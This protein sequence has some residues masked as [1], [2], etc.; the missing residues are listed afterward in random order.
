VLG[1]GLFGGL[2]LFTGYGFCGAPVTAG[3]AVL[4][5]L[6]ARNGERRT[7][8]LILAILGIAAVVFAWG[9]HWDR[10]TQVFGPSMPA[11][12]DYPRFC[13]LMFTSLLG[14][15][16]V[17]AATLVH[18]PA[19][20]AMSPVATQI[21]SASLVAVGAVLLVAVVVVFLVAARR[22]WRGQATARAKAVWVLA[23][24]S[25]LYA[26]LTAFGRLPVTIDAAFLWRYSTLVTPAVCGLAIAAEATLIARQR[27]L[28]R[29]LLIGWVVLAAVIWSNVSP[30]RNAAAIAKGK[31]RWIASYLK[32]RDLGAANRESDFVVYFPAP[33]SP[34]IARRLQWL[35][36]R[37]FSFFRDSIDGRSGAH[38]PA[39]ENER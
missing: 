12:W 24:T 8:V 4:L 39:A 17:F 19:A 22:I 37:H 7:A 28:A 32:T 5:W 38:S 21:V 1:V 2:T 29:S 36:G 33:Q 6:R 20:G 3:L 13:A 34:L 15:R 35:D 10:G 31:D 27:I 23:G 14:L 25:L 16:S 26:G 18:G 9:Y 30:E 11:W